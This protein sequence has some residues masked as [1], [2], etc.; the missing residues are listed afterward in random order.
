MRDPAVSE[1][2]DVTTGVK[3]NN[4]S[5]ID[6]SAGVE[7]LSADVNQR[8]SLNKVLISTGSSLQVKIVDTA[9]RILLP[10]I[11]FGTGGGTFGPVT[12]EKGQFKGGPGKAVNVQAS[13]TM[14]ISIQ[15][16]GDVVEL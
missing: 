6:A 9:G 5:S 16:T 14:N 11:F 8:Q 7:V 15:I 2:F 10:D 3:T 1:K 13:G 12:F 4:K